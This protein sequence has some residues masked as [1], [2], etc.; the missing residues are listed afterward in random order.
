MVLSRAISKYR[1]IITLCLILVGSLVSITAD[2]RTSSMLERVASLISSG[3]YPFQKGVAALRGFRADAFEVVG[4]VAALR[5]ENEELRK[6]AESLFP[7]VVRSR[8]LEKE[9]KRL[10]DLLRFAEKNEFSFEPV[11]LAGRDAT[12]WFSTVTVDKGMKHRIGKN[13]CVITD[14]GV[15]GKILGV[16]PFTARVLLLS[17]SN[18][19]VGALVQRTRARGIVQGNDR[20][21][22][23]MKYLDPMADVERGDLVVT[24]GDSLIFPKGLAIGVVTRVERE[25][26]ALLKWAEVEPS[27]EFSQLEEAFVILP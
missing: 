25:R 19:R 4:S 6:R 21:G 17:D 3:F 10:R 11:E 15:V 26:G 5:Q 24:S 14:K 27:V 8:E 9:N 13:M 22:C 16:G 1:A 12:S 18:S 7:V 23:L 20:G 2:V